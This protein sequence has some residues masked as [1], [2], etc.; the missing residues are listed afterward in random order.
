MKLSSEFLVIFPFATIMFGERSGLATSQIGVITAVG[1]ALSVLLEIPTGVI[2]DAWPRKYSLVGAQISKILSLMAWWWLPNFNGYMLGAALFAAGS[3]FESGALQAYL[4]NI[5]GRAKQQRF[6]AF[7]ARLQALV[8]LS[9]TAAFI[10]AS[11]IGL[12]YEL[13]L[14]CSLA[15]S[16]LSLLFSLSLPTDSL[17]LTPG[18]QPR[19]F[20]SAIRHIMGS[21]PLAQ[22]LLGALIVIIVSETIIEFS[23]LY[24][25]SAGI[26]IHA[27][28]LILAGGNIIG[29]VSFWLLPRYT[30][31]LEKHKIWL[32]MIVGVIFVVTLRFGGLVGL[33]VG[34]ITVTR[35]L[36]VLQ[37]QFDATIQH[38]AN[39]KTRATVSSI[40][41]F[42]AKLGAAALTASIG[43]IAGTESI[44]QP[45]RIA[46]VIGLASFAAMQVALWHRQTR[47]YTSE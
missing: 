32:S 6:G 1:L 31:Q 42:G 7:W 4:Y 28:P 44:L 43:A 35:F 8:M 11:V 36:R 20:K 12:R 46:I 10:T 2:A 9:Y 27:I 33:V 18:E 22:L 23:S 19:I 39:D 5:T 40:G 38:L 30:T 14:G 41:S 24:Y 47:L 3:A 16:C 26:G 15:A 34:L 25:R 17:H 37:V 45:F 29:A 21:K 13:L